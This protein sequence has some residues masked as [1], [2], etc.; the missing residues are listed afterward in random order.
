MAKAPANILRSVREKLGLSQAAVAAKLNITPA[1]VGHYEKGIAKPPI[2]RAKQLARL[3][4]ID[5]AKIEV[6][7][8]AMRGSRKVVVNDSDRLS[9]T[10][11]EVVDALRS[12][13]L[14]KRRPVVAMVLGYVDRVNGD[15]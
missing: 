4:K 9:E 12:L 1:A 8:R 3:L 11:R 13:P 14:A 7:D 6:S 2:E 15:E 5:V 10:E